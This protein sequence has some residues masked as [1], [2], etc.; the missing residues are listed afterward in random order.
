[1]TTQTQTLRPGLLVSLKTSIKG[2]VS[3]IKKDL[4]A[5]LTEAGVSK[6]RW[7][8]E[9][10]I[11][12]AAEYETATTTRGKARSLIGAVC[13][14]SAFG[15]LCPEQDAPLLEKAIAEARALA[16]TFNAT[17]KLSRVHLY[18]IA[19]RIAADDVE[20][21][22]AI[23]SEVRDLLDDMA[24]GVKNFD[25]KVIREAAAKA[26]QIGSMLTPEMQARITVA[27]EAARS[28]ATKLVA[29]GETAAKEIDV[30][31][32]RAL[33]EARTAFLDLDDAKAIAA[34]AVAGRA[35]DLQ[36]DVGVKLA[37]VEPGRKLELI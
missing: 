26:K 22:K 29:A 23:S 33:T 36:A 21:V 13:T 10:T 1:M 3:Y 2:N 6:A 8:T 31:A 12:D 16:E 5:A 11:A 34:P 9:R 18:V 35:V 19:G 7:E 30:R 17:A 4:D 37:A 28:A 24:E 32:V 15:L 14:K 25:V 20:A 27:I